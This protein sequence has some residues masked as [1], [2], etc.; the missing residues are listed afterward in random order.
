MKKILPVLITVLI[1]AA[2]YYSGILNNEKVIEVT[3]GIISTLVGW[4]ETGASALIELI[5]GHS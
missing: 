2:V 1:A 4:L 5:K 3:S